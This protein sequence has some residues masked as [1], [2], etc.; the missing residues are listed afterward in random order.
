MGWSLLLS[1]STG[2]R[3]RIQQLCANVSRSR[4]IEQ[5][6]NCI[7][8]LVNR[9]QTGKVLLQLWTWC[10]S[11]DALHNARCVTYWQL[12]KGLALVATTESCCMPTVSPQ[13]RTI[14]YSF[15]VASQVTA[16]LN[17]RFLIDAIVLIA[18]LCLL[19]VICCFI[20]R[21]ITVGLHKVSNAS[22]PPKRWSLWS[23]ARHK[24]A[25]VAGP[26]CVIA[27]W[28][29]TIDLMFGLLVSGSLQ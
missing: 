11:D 22:L 26:K 17:H 21:M 12:D 3:Y 16:L 5:V 19:C 10:W 1:S 15:L 24:P 4:F 18:Q 25:A 14:L 13:H 29:I 7:D 8:S 23:S 2:Q 27:W 28:V 9:R 20:H 6:T